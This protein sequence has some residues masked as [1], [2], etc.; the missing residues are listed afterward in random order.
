[1]VH[2]LGR[3]HQTWAT[4][5]V[6]VDAAVGA[7][8][9]AGYARRVERLARPVITRPR[10]RPPVRRSPLQAVVALLAAQKVEVETLATRP[11][12]WAHDGF[13]AVAVVL[14]PLAPIEA[15]P[16]PIEVYRP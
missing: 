7:L 1:M 16:H 8:V 6:V 3:A 4:P 14:R 13:D 9:G 11:V 15:L 10:R 12:A 2:V 5:V